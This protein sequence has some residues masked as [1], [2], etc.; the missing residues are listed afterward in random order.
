VRVLF[1]YD[2]IR[3]LV[4]R[5]GKQLRDVTAIEQESVLDAFALRRDDILD[6]DRSEVLRDVL[7]EKREVPCDVV[8]LA[9]ASN[10]SRRPARVRRGGTSG[11]LLKSL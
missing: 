7:G 2:G 9:L 3:D 1:E 5:T 4:L 6:L 11:L 8:R 10:V